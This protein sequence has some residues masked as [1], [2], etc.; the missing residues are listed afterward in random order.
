M[1]ALVVVDVAP[2]RE[3]ALA[4]AEIGEAAP[5]QDLGRQCAVEALVLALGLGMVGAAVGDADAEPHQPHGEHGVGLAAGVAPRRAVVHQHR[6][7]QP[8]APEDGAQPLAHRL[9]ALVGAGGERERVAR[10]VVE[11]RQGNGSARPRSRSGP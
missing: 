5:G 9:R 11:H 8:V 3:C 7:G 6:L 2:A 1:R 4:L 10:V